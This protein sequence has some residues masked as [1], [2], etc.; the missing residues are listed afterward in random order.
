MLESIIKYYEPF[1]DLFDFTIIDD[2]SQIEP[3][4]RKILPDWIRGIRIEEDHGW[5]NEVCKNILIRESANEWNAL[6]DLDYI[7]DLDHEHTFNL[8]TKTFILHFNNL[9]HLKVCFQFQKGTRV[10]YDDWTKEVDE[11]G[12]I[13]SYIISRTAFMNTYGYDSAFYWYYGADNT[14]FQQLDD[15]IILDNTQVRKIAKQ[16]APRDLEPG[17]P[18]IYIPI[19]SYK[20]HLHNIGVF[21]KDT[22]RWISEEVRQSYGKPLPKTVAI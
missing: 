2:G 19:N 13:N 7:I 14:L 12:N 15:E 17:D 11:Y 16:G 20:Q 3:L 18:S 10:Q 22:L 21:N 8:L 5:G 4:S 1:K 9:K 6:F